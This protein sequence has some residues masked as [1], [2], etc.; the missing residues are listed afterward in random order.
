LAIA[1]ST[2]WA[3]RQES[4]TGLVLVGSYACGRP[5]MASDVDLVVLTADSAAYTDD[6]AWI[7]DLYPGARLI[8]TAVWGP[9]I[10]RRLR[11]AS[12]LQVELGITEPQWAARP[13]DEGTARVLSGGYRI[14]HDLR[15]ELAAAAASLTRSSTVLTVAGTEA[16]PCFHHPAAERTA[17]ATSAMG[18]RVV[19][20]SKSATPA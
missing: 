9:V 18:R 1:E 13:L 12:G 10:E 14:L 7:D 5:S 17:V 2:V 8:R 16:S 3:T 19:S 4:V 6:V 15:G 20:T 11:L